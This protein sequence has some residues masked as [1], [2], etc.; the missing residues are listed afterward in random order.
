MIRPDWLF[1]IS[2]EENIHSCTVTQMFS[3]TFITGRS[4]QIKTSSE[5]LKLSPSLS[6][7]AKWYL[8]MALFSLDF[9]YFL[10]QIQGGLLDIKIPFQF[11]R[12]QNSIPILK[13]V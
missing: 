9:Y 12:Y 2:T 10:E 5:I 13:K 7:V 11:V 4:N 3:S 6:L 1:Q 8:S